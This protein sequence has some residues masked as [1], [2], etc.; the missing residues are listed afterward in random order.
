M[1]VSQLQRW[2]REVK[3]K[4]FKAGKM[5]GNQSRNPGNNQHKRHH[6][7]QQPGFQLW[8]NLVLTV[9]LAVQMFCVLSGMGRSCWPFSGVWC[10][11]GTR[12]KQA[13]M[14]HLGANA[15]SS[16]E[17]H[18]RSQSEHACREEDR[19]FPPDL[20]GSQQT[21]KGKTISSVCIGVS[22][23]TLAK[24]FSPREQAPW[25]AFLAAVNL[26]IVCTGPLLLFA[27][28]SLFRLCSFQHLHLIRLHNN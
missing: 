20:M 1:S 8:R 26:L 16:E 9:I 6:N 18:Y 4:F 14:G 25:E 5:L 3:V 24:Q 27:I 7:I 21:W 17:P 12:C 28:V 19:A 11:K 2:S 23:T 22:W 10:Y 15:G 13:E